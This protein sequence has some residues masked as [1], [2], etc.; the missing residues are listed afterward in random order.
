MPIELTKDHLRYMNLGKRF[1]GAYIKGFRPQQQSESLQNYLDNWPEFLRAGMGVFVWG[2]NS[3]GKTHVAA[4]LCKAVWGRYRVSSYLVTAEE[5]KEC[6]I[7]NSIE[8]H[9]GSHE[10]MVER[11]LDV[12]FLFIDDLAKEYRTESGFAENKLG[13]LLRRR[14]KEFKVTSVTTNLSPTQFK[15]VYGESSF[16]LTKEG[17]I[18]CKIEGENMRERVLKNIRQQIK[19]GR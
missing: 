8:A 18:P 2:S 17:M 7:D 5:L 4:A 10:F 13:N 3:V 6:W 9:P 15:G 16:E 1:W 11:I 12:R 19:S 14:Q